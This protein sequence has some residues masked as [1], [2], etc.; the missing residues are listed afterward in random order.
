MGTRHLICASVDGVTKL[1]QYGQWDGYPEGQ[2]RDIMEFV[3]GN[4]MELGKRNQFLDNLRNSYFLTDEMCEEVDDGKR[5]RPASANRD[6]GAKVLGLIMEGP[7]GLID[8]FE[9]G[10]DSLMCEWAYWLDF[11]KN[12]LEVYKGFNAKNGEP[13]VNNRFGNPLPDTFTYA[14][15]NEGR[16]E[17][18]PVRFIH[19]FA[20]DRLPDEHSFMHL[21]E[22]VAG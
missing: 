21:L 9:F 17:Y 20:L 12:E 22:A 14:N 5:T 1:A 10:K 3:E 2:G 6:L 13:W 16:N 11:D 8:D 19:S 15:G 4:L 7:Q 18:N